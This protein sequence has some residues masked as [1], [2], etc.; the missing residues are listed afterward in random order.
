[1]LYTKLNRHLHQLLTG[2]EHNFYFA[3]QNAVTDI[4]YTVNFYEKVHN[5]A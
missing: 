2:P 3:S 4:R 5:T 1:L